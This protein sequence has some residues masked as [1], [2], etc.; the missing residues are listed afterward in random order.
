MR[1][2]S[3]LRRLLCG[4]ED[5]A[6]DE[7]LLATALQP[8]GGYSRDSPPFRYLVSVLARMNATER[9]EFLQVRRRAA[10]AA[11][12][13]ALARSYRSVTRPQF[14]TGSPQLPPGG[15]TALRP[16]I[17]VSRAVLHSG[18]HSGGDL[19]TAVTRAGTCF[20]QLHLPEYSSAE[21]LRERLLFSIRGSK[22]LIDRT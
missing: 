6:W 9:R 4:P 18:E 14:A 8:T 22:G 15:I 7:S 16:P 21:V 11:A 20:H 10:T 5:V 12:V 3:Q 17:K 19:D 13:H 1:R 2:P